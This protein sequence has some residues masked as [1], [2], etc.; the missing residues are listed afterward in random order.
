MMLSL[1]KLK[2]GSR[3]EDGRVIAQWN[4]VLGRSWFEAENAKYH[5][6]G[7]AVAQGFDGW[8]V[9]FGYKIHAPL[10]MSEISLAA[11]SADSFVPLTEK[12][13]PHDHPAPTTATSPSPSCP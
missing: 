10:E 11:R 9:Y 8:V 5:L 2:Y 3:S 1:A 4:D 6:Q 12:A 7:Y 13:A